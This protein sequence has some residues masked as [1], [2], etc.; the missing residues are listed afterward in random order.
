MA[1][2]DANIILE[3]SRQQ[4]QGQQNLLNNLMNLANQ[5]HKRQADEETLLRQETRAA[6]EQANDPTNIAVMKRQ[7]LPVTP[8]QE[9]IL[10]QSIADK[11]AASYR[12]NPVTGR[13][14]PTYVPAGQ[15]IA[16]QAPVDLLPSPSAADFAPTGVPADI[17]ESPVLAMERAKA[18]IDVEKAERIGT[19]A[20]ERKQ[21]AEEF[22]ER[23][24]AKQTVSMVDDMI[25]F[26]KGTV[27]LP[28]AGA[29]QGVARFTSPEKA[30]NM[31]LLQQSRLRLA[32]PLAKQLGVNPP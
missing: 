25:K 24:M 31:A 13:L 21:K 32:A 1:I 14:E 2:F 28:Y 22:K 10:A 26:N 4:Q 20:Q 29:V 11:Q 30:K 8:Q 23:K 9:A 5:Y 19:A 16:P 12:Q 17:A 3:G 27:D 18:D 15:G 7:G 6:A